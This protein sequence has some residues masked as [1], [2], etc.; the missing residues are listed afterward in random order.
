MQEATPTLT[1]QLD[2]VLENLTLA[3]RGDFLARA[4]E[5]MINRYERTP[6]H[7]ATS[8]ERRLFQAELDALKETLTRHQRLRES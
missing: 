8:A 6:P 3:Q 2:A 5:G 7:C 4:L 1:T